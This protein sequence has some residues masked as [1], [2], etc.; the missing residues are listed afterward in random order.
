MLKNFTLTLK[1]KNVTHQITSPTRSATFLLGEPRNVTDE[2]P[3]WLLGLKCRQGQL[4]TEPTSVHWIHRDTRLWSWVT[5]L[6]QPGH[7]SAGCKGE[8]P[9]IGQDVQ[10]PPSWG[11]ATA[12]PRSLSFPVSTARSRKSQSQHCRLSNSKML[13]LSF[14]ALEAEEFASCRPHSR[15]APESQTRGSRGE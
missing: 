5:S 12:N 3:A 9:W 13:S 14:W 15:C 2:A 8:G 1:Y 7:D 6:G 10:G 11:R 4:I